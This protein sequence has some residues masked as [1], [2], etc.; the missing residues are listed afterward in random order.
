M[1]IDSHHHFWTYSAR[2]YGWIDES[3][4]KIRRDFLPAD[5]QREIREAGVDRVVS[6]QARQTVEDTRW[7]LDLAEE[8]PWIAG[9]VG[10]VPLAEASLNDVLADLK[11]RPKLKGVRHILQG[12]PDSFFEREDFNHGVSQ[13]RAHGLV[14]DVLVSERQLPAALAFVDRHPKQPM[15]IDHIAKPRIRDGLVEPWARLIRELARRPHV[16]CKVSGMVTEADFLH[17]QDGQLKPYFDVVL[18]AFGP[19]RLMFG[20]DWPVC[21]V[22]SSYQRW[23]TLVERWTAAWSESEKAAFWSGTAQRTYGL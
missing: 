17:W 4:A 23:H 12:E 3:M 10:W 13:L 9:V 22:A 1:K 20:T 11:Q 6:V 21:L 18:S 8:R 7:L 5:L 16:V 2:E 15:V 19:N 14:Y